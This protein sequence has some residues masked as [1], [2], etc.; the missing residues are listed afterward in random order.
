MPKSSRKLTPEGLLRS[1]AVL[2]R[3][4]DFDYT[5]KEL[6]LEGDGTITITR[7]ME[8]LRHPDTLKSLRGAPITLGHP[9]EGVTPE[10]WKKE[11]VGAIAGDPAMDSNTIIG[12]VLIGDKEALKRLDDGIAELSIGY[13]FVMGSD[14]ATIGALRVNHVAL[15]ER[16]RAGSSVRVLD[17]LDNNDP[18]KSL[19]GDDEMP[20]TK[21]E[22]M[23]AMKDAANAALD[24]AMKRQKMDATNTD[25]MK[26][27]LK[28]TID[29]MMKPIM[30]D[31]KKMKDEA[32]DQKKAI[33]TEKQA[34]IDTENR[35]KAE[36]AAKALTDQVRAEE[37][38]RY[39]VVADALPLIDED[40]REAVMQAD[41]KT[42]LVAALDGVVDDAKNKSV[43]YLRGALS[44]AK[45]KLHNDELPPGVYA[46]DSKRVK[47]T[48]ARKK[49]E[50]DFIAL[51]S[52]TY[53]DGGGR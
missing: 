38:D 43:D 46:F 17:S 2:T 18:D 47:A 27:V 16:G 3:A 10:N 48:D 5:R 31:M 21:Q 15:V 19:E 22:M 35:K 25:A 52:K 44:L 45:E 49:A 33:D 14:Y 32:A 13:D 37:R 53:T 8:S 4:G 40:K 20:M 1:G 24:A 29:A 36:D 26:G 7:T 39:S 50:D 30:E 41:V 12:D 11:V 6:G 28:D 23:D 51:Q 9:P 34:K 42:V